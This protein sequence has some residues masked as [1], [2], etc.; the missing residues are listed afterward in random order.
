MDSHCFFG[1]IPVIVC[2]RGPMADTDMTSVN[3]VFTFMDG[4]RGQE[5]QSCDLNAASIDGRL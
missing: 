2:P 4:K 5:F 1:L 3:V